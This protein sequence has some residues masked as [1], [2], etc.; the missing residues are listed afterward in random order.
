MADLWLA[1]GDHYQPNKH[2]VHEAWADG[3]PYVYRYE[4]NKARA[5][6]ERL[7]AEIPVLPPYDP[8]KDRKL[9]WEDE[10]NAAI[11][12][13]RTEK[14]AEQGKE[15]MKRESEKDEV[16]PKGVEQ[17]TEEKKI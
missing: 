9:S 1:I 7:A 10:L 12:K 3:E 13:R 6:W 5:L 14:E 15:E 4:L 16:L 2:A 11:Q 8:A 17:E